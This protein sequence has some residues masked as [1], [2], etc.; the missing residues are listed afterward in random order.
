MGLSLIVALLV[1]AVFAMFI[2]VIVNAINISE[3]ERKNN[4]LTED[5]QFLIKEKKKE[6]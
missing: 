3:L 5:V 1:L 2:L 4:Q 6:K